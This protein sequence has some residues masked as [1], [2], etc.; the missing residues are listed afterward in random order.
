MDSGNL[1]L[2]LDF[3]RWM[4]DHLS[5]DPEPPALLERRVTTFRAFGAWGRAE[6]G[7][8]TAIVAALSL[9]A[10]LY[11][12][13]CMKRDV[14]YYDEGLI[15]FGAARVL[16][17]AIPHRDFYTAYGPGQFYVLAALY[18]VFGTSILVE[19]AWDTVVRCC[20]VVPVFIIVG[21][22]APRRLAVLT[23]AASLVWLASFGF[24]GYPVFPALA[25]ALAGL[26]FLAPALGGVRLSSRLAAAGVFAGVTLLF[27]YD[28]G[29]FTFGAEC[30]IL[31]LSV[32]F[33][34]RG[35]AECLP[36]T[37]RALILF[38]L[39]F[40]VVVAPITVAF[41]FSGAIPD[42][43][44]DVLIFQTQF[45]VKMRSLPFPDLSSLWAHPMG[46]AVYLP[47][48]LCA[49]AVPTMVAVARYPGEDEIV[50]SRPTA[51][52]ALLWT[53]V[54]LVVLTLILFGKGVVRVSTI[55]MA[56][57][58]I[59]SLAVAGV[60]SQS[61]PG[62]GPLGRSLVVLGLLASSVLTLGCLYI[63]LREAA[64]NVAW[65]RDPAS[66]ELSASDAPPV[67]GSCSMPRGLERLA[68]F[69]TNEAIM[70]TILYVQQ[71]TSPDDQVFVGLS[72]HD[73]ISINDVLLYFAMNR[74]SATKWH[75]FNPGLQTSA[76]IQHE[77]VG[78][79]ERAK[80]KLI[81]IEAIGADVQ[82]PNDS[83]FSSG[84]TVLDDYLRQAFEPIAT[85]G[86]NIVLRA[87]SPGQP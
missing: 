56:M 84:V 11:L 39:G 87:R 30:A 77:M 19:R 75:E 59:A 49:A 73:K 44:F 23:A 82:E 57:A 5:R 72:R 26:A 37:M 27:R 71:R 10:L 83:A 32:W 45:Y 69:R 74:K 41:A 15:L 2:G 34:T 50:G 80:P 58:V 1:A 8:S 21:Q 62:R 64:Q 79:L 7:P 51:R 25:A 63:G 78:E 66:W 52:P 28:V 35:R 13:L 55:H 68:C 22:V 6:L 67:S 17:G 14:N 65:A 9:V 70:E 40:A 43:V 12:T 86:S 48:V 3:I 76:P 54:A 61:I 36:A 29:F 16:D 46:F 85:F 4:P 18:K 42:L 53:L 47:L 24:Y 20:I 60:M 81:V 38:G 33:Q 31:A